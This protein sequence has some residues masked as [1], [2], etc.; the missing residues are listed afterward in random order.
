MASTRRFRSARRLASRPEE[1]EDRVSED[2]EPGR[3]AVEA[4][5]VAW[6]LTAVAGLAA[7]HALARW[8]AARASAGHPAARR[9]ADAVRRLR[10][11]GVRVRSGD[12]AGSEVDGLSRPARPADRRDRAGRAGPGPVRR[13]RGAVRRGVPDAGRLLPGGPAVVPAARPR[14]APAARRPVSEGRHRRGG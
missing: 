14:P 8:S 2:V 10:V 3:P 9:P 7:A 13:R 12:P 6:V 11:G 5:F 1:A 4:V